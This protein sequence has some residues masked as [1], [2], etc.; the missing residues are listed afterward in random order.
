MVALYNLREEDYIY[1]YILF[2]F[3]GKSDDTIVANY[4]IVYAK[5]YIYLEKLKN[6]NKNTI[7]NVYILGYLSHL[8]YIL[9]MEESICIQN[10]QNLM[11]NK[12]IIIYENL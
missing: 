9:K 4:Y 11:F 8:K 12:F 6:K 3:P 2:G 5:P 1:E 10:N 7:F